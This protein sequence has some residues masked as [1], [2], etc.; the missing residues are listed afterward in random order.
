MRDI[1]PNT[2]ALYSLIK[3]A[4]ISSVIEPLHPLFFLEN[5]KNRYFC[6][7][8][9]LLIGFSRKISAKKSFPLITVMG[10][11]GPITHCYLE[12]RYEF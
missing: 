10:P 6:I 9:Q 11:S 3:S 2:I 4:L 7:V 12:F 8:I 5:Y 1:L